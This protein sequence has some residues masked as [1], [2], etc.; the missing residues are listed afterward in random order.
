MYE[1]IMISDVALSPIEMQKLA[2]DL[3]DGELFI[4]FLTV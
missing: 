4:E 1:L 3:S 2:G